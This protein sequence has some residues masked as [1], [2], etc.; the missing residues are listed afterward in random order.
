M[1]R[2][3]AFVRFA[4]C[5]EKRQ[6]NAVGQYLKLSRLL[7]HLYSE[8][9]SLAWFG[10]DHVWRNA[11]ARLSRTQQNQSLFKRLAEC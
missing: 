6:E 5:A 10:I 9:Y 11:Q 2:R 1:H 4:V 3:K 7:H 8:F